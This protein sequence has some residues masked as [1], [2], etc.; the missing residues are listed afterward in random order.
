MKND[1]TATFKLKKIGSI[2]LTVVPYIIYI[3][4][5]HVHIAVILHFVSITY[6]LSILKSNNCCIDF[7]GALIML[8]LITILLP[9][10]LEENFFSL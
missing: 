1:E 9:I 7:H 3:V 8:S 5:N 10:F 2:I 6:N 4:S